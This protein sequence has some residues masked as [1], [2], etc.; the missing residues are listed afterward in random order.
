[1][2]LTIEY[3]IHFK[4]GFRGRRRMQ[5]G[6]APALVEVE[7]GSIPRVS[8]LMALAIRF[9]GLVRSGAVQDY[10]DLARLGKR[11]G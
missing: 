2:G 9:E 1:M 8:R 5:T 3:Q 6:S 10:A 4:A 11:P 7:A